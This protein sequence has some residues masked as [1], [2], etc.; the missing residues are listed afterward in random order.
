MRPELCSAGMY[1]RDGDDAKALLDHNPNPDEEEIRAA[2]DGNICRAGVRQIVD[3][4]RLLA[5]EGWRKRW[6]IRDYR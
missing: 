4:V 2:I 5:Q 1:T 6:E 3:A